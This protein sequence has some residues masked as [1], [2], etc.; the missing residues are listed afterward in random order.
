VKEIKLGSLYKVRDHENKEVIIR[1][2]DGETEFKQMGLSQG[3]IHFANP[4]T[5]SYMGFCGVEWF[6][7]HAKQ[8][9]K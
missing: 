4:Y 1:A 6:K 5:G 8:V 2:V 9:D 3:F 7:E